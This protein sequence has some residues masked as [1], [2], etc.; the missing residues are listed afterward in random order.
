MT[1][2]MEEEGEETV[3]WVMRRTK[4]IGWRDEG[5][6]DHD[7]K[8]EVRTVEGRRGVADPVRAAAGG[9]GR[10]GGGANK[11]SGR[12]WAIWTHYN[13]VELSHLKDTPPLLEGRRCEE[14]LAVFSPSDNNS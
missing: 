4:K 9:G 10:E 14:V 13:W 6:E 12:H 3:E 8:G 5:R 1:M 2:T 7:G 11:L